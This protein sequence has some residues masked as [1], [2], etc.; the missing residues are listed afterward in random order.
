MGENMGKGNAF[1]TKTRF[2]R[3]HD[4]LSGAYTTSSDPHR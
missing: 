2:Q 4:Q 3:D 1:D